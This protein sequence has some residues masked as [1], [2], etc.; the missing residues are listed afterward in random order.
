[1]VSPEFFRVLGKPLFVG[2]DFS[3]FGLSPSLRSEAQALPIILSHDLWR[4]HFGAERK[5]IGQLIEL[6]VQPY[7]YIV[8]GVASQGGAFPANVD[9]WVPSHLVSHT[10]IQGAGLPAGS[11]GAI[12]LL[13]PETPLAA[14][15]NEIQAWPGQRLFPAGSDGPIRLI[16]IREHWAGEV[17]PLGIRLSIASLVFLA[18]VIVSAATLFR[19]RAEIRRDEFAIRTALGAEPRRILAE[20]CAETAPLIVASLAGSLLVRVAVVTL[21]K[22]AVVFP[23]SFDSSVSI[24]EFSIVIISAL[25][26][27]SIFLGLHAWELARLPWSNIGHDLGAGW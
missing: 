13:K 26:V 24:T 9:G 2:Q 22:H 7:S 16:P 14:A 27:L 15:Q 25:I 10:V 23:P 1:M 20:L 8:T 11:G 18:L 6:N 17:Y 12:A 21:L 3:T 19:A 4:L 5:V